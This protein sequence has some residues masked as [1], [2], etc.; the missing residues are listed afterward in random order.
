MDQKLSTDVEREDH[1]SSGRY[2]IRLP[3]DAEAELTYMRRADGT[4]VA[5]HTYVPPRFRGNNIAEKLVQRL[6]EDA[7]GDMTKILP[8]CSYVAAQFRRHPEWADL[9]A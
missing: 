5:D 4:L 9:A 6:I 7:R 1:G 2:V 8:L 3:D